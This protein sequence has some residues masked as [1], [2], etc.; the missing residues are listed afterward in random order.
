MY[1]KS[2]QYSIFPSRPFTATRRP[3]NPLAAFLA[4]ERDGSEM[5]VMCFFQ[6]LSLDFQ[7][8]DFYS[9]KTVL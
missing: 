8:L 5:R 1:Y 2:S 4:T 9:L 6:S 7:I 3:P